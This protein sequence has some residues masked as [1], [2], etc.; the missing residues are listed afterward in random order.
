MAKPSGIGESA[1]LC[2]VGTDLADLDWP[3]LEADLDQSG[4]A[5]APGLLAP[6]TC[7]A[8]IGLYDA[9]DGFR[10][11]VVM[12]RHGFGRGEYKYFAY[13]LPKAVTRLREAF[14]LR[15]AP[16]ADRWR[17]ALGEAGRFP[18]A[19][20]DY[21]AECHAA[22]QPRPTPLM[23]RYGPGDYNRLHQDLYGERVF[24][25][26]LTILLSAP[27]R[28]FAGGEFVLTQQ[29]PRRQSRVEVVSLTQGDA[30]IFAVSHRPQKGAR[31]IHRVNLRH[32][33]SRLRRGER[34]T[35]GI[36]FHDAA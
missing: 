29:E 27:G 28:D 12:E 24:P 26:Q 14:Y 20:A 5:V 19:L 1:G 15:L 22:G 33:V 17:A 25:L 8:L 30:V 13:P 3:A 2:Q 32:G 34:F 16:I 31:G 6:E 9:P 7:R 4:F 35:L 36:I 21:L 23:L 10:S 11:R 18:P